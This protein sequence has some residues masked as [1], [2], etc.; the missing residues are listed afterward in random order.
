MSAMAD[1][2][3]VMTSPDVVTYADG[4]GIWH[5]RIRVTPGA[6]T[7][8]LSAHELAYMAR[9]AIAGELTARDAA[10]PAYLARLQIVR[11]NP[12]GERDGWV[13]FREGPA[14]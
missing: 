6:G 12:L 7:S 1:I 9:C 14:S 3:A 13:T 11:V 2:H 10:S 5:A 8:D 4:F